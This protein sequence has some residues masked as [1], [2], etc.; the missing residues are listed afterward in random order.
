[1]AKNTKNVKETNKKVEPEKIEE[2]KVQETEDG[3]KNEAP[4][5]VELLRAQI[6]EMK[7]AMAEMA[8]KASVPSQSILVKEAEDEVEIGCRMLQGIGLVS[9]DGTVSID[10]KFNDVQSA[11]ISEIKKL[12]R[13]SHIKKL[14]EDGICYFV[15]EADYEIFSIRNYK[16]LSDENLISLLTLNN[17]NDIIKKLDIITEYKRNS[18]VLNCI[19][20]RICN[21]IIKGQLKDW[22]YYVRK[23]IE[24]YFDIE[25]DR[26]ISILNSIRTLRQ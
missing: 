22:D 16:D 21:M 14:F 9:D 15:D 1:M 24:S 18:N 20:Y 2:V 13:K 23:G 19:I 4:S 6:E 5:E 11:T 12:F 8:T 10:L 17:V 26:G 25:F 7:K 3:Q